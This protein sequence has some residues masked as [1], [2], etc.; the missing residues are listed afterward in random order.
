VAGLSEV[1]LEAVENATEAKVQAV[2]LSKNNF[3]AFPE[4]RKKWQLSVYTVGYRLNG[5]YILP[6]LGYRH[7]YDD[8]D[9]V[10]FNPYSSII[11]KEKCART[12]FVRS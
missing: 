10:F 12:F 5:K 8:F 3:N 6:T 11:I 4:V 7:Q 9:G 1:P 2:D